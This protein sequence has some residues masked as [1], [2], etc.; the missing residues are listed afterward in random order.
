M[1]L[2]TVFVDEENGFEMDIHIN[3]NDKVY[4]GITNTE[5]PNNMFG[6]MTLDYEDF[7]SFKEMV[8]KLWDEMLEIHNT[9][10]KK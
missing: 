5:D 3:T 8:N 4:V 9:P 2:K 10:I 6:F 7:R 1:P